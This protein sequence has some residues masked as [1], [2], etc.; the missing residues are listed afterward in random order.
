MIGGVDSPHRQR[1]RRLTNEGSQDGHQFVMLI[2]FRQASRRA[3][4]VHDEP[5]IGRRIEIG[6][7]Q[8]DAPV[9][10]LH[11]FEKLGGELDALHQQLVPVEARLRLKIRCHARF[12]STPPLH[13]PDKAP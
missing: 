12:R 9:G 7:E 13:P 6:F 11:A 5:G 2:P 1:P 10:M 3:H 8:I 4:R